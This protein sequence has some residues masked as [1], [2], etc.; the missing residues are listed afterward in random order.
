MALT[1]T[2]LRSLI[3]F[4]MTSASRS[5]RTGI[6]GG[7]AGQKFLSVEL[8][9]GRPVEGMGKTAPLVVSVQLHFAG[10]VEIVEGHLAA[11]GGFLHGLAAGS[12]GAGECGLKV[13]TNIHLFPLISRRINNNL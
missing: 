7:L 12:A 4:G 2:R 11:G 5:M 8:L 10:L 1:S 3:R 9:G 13:L 6:A